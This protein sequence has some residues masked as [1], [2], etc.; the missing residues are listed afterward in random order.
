M[1]LVDATHEDVRT[2][3][4]A[5]TI[6]PLLLHFVVALHSM[7]GVVGWPRFMDTRFTGGP[8][9]S[10]EARALAEGIK[11]RTTMPYADGEE[12]LAWAQSATEVRQA[13]RHLDMPLVVITRGRWDGLR[14]LSED[15]RHSIRHAWE[16]MQ[17]D[18]VTL[19]SQGAYVVASNSEHYVQLEQPNLVID[20]IRGT[21]AA[22]RGQSTDTRR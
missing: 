1:V 18:L 4:P 13:R 2:R 16:D 15:Q 12:S 5:S 3:I 8:A 9:M 6:N 22:A 14:G 19:S 21:L 20:A 7:M 17:R 11:F 10:A